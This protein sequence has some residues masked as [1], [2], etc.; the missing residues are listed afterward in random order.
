MFS[1]DVTV[2]VTLNILQ[3]ICST[4]NVSNVMGFHRVFN[5]NSIITKSQSGTEV[6]TPKSN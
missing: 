6:T 4:N 5:P 1:K 2:T 3:C